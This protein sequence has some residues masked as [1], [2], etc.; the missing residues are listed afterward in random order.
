MSERTTLQPCWYCGAPLNAVSKML[1][2]GDPQPGDVCVSVCIYCGHLHMIERGADGE[3]TRRRPTEEE[4][5]ELMADPD[6]RRVVSA[7]KT[8]GPRKFVPLDQR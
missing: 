2:D 5:H 4:H 1:G 7:V 6:V 3:W 8:H